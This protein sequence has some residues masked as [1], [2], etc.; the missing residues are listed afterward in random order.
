MYASM[1]MG[2]S[3][4]LGALY[5]K[6]LSYKYLDRKDQIALCQ[7]RLNKSLNVSTGELER[8]SLSCSSTCLF[9]KCPRGDQPY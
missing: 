6:I 9:S 3:L 2:R 5:E 8:E 7:I 1:F 4:R